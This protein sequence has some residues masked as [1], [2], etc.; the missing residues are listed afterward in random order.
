MV[1]NSRDHLVGR[2]CLVGT[3]QG[4]CQIFSSA[5]DRAAERGGGCRVCVR[6]LKESLMMVQPFSVAHEAHLLLEVGMG[7]PWGLE[8]TKN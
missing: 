8:K 5:Q 2:G 7:G 4:G 6:E 1:T 3:G